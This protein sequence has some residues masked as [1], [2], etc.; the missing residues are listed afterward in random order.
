L[1]NWGGQRFVVIRE[2]LNVS[3]YLQG[4]YRDNNEEGYEDDGKLKKR[5]LHAP[6]GAVDGVGLAEDTSQ[7]PP[8]T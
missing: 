6:L 5:F 2:S 7:P 8:L 3:D 4:Y 1:S